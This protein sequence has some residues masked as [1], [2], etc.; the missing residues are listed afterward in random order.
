M[1][2]VL[3]DLEDPTKVNFLP[4]YVRDF[5]EL[6]YNKTAIMFEVRDVPK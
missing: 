2:A 4:E 6:C 5:T 3:F 1:G